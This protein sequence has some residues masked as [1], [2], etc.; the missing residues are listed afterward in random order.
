MRLL[1]FDLALDSL[2]TDVS[3]ARNEQLIHA[4]ISLQSAKENAIEGGK[5]NWSKVP[6]YVCNEGTTGLLYSN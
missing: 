4:H 3:V 2:E 5:L 1:V 6:S